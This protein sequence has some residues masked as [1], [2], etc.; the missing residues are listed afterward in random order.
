MSPAEA[1]EHVSQRL[2]GLDPQARAA[3]SLLELVGRARSD[4]A[5]ERGWSEAEVGDALARGRK[6]LRR[7]LLQLPGTG[8]CERAERL[9]SDDLDGVLDDRG[10]RV[11]SGHLARCERCVE[12]DRK[13]AQARD[14]LVRELE[15]A[16][17]VRPEPR[18]APEPPGEPEPEVIELPDTE[19][20]EERE[21]EIVEVEQETAPEPTVEDDVAAAV[22]K[23]SITEALGNVAW[24]GMFGIAVL[25]AVLSIVLVVAAT[26]G[27]VDRIF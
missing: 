21:V 17:P 24:L 5:A 14:G 12:H 2:P 10:A 8:W 4:I 6:A 11:L 13:L 7:S 1:M 25:L 18:L 19:P 26:V 3:L 27:G 22:V 23:R 15:E 20:T 16:E 9:L